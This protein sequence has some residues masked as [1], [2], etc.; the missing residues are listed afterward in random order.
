[1]A[2]DI[3]NETTLSE[4]VDNEKSEFTVGSTTN[5]TAGTSLLVVQGT[6]GQEV[7][8]VSTIPVS[9]TV[10]VRRGYNGTRALN[11]PSGARVFIAAPTDLKRDWGYVDRAGNHVQLVGASGNYPSYALPGTRARDGIG[12]EYICVE[13]TAT[14]YSGTTVV[15]SKD[16]NFT[17]VQ[18]VGGTQGSIGLLVEPATSDQ[19]AWAQIYG[20]NS[21][22]QIDANSAA[23]SGWIAVPATSVSTPSVGLALLQA[24]TTTAAYVIHGMFVVG[25]ATSTVTS[26]TSATGIAIP[27]FL[28][29]PYTL[30]RL[31]DVFTSNT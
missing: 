15:I 25:S 23:S 18:A 8:H 22:A 30:N 4:A 28:N 9:G 17:A 31:E 12:N 3:L 10:K 1:M 11:H 24:A 6:A 19:Y 29:Y 26:A 21:F 2:V 5:I 7:M 27:V 13:L 20:Y 14:A 16:G